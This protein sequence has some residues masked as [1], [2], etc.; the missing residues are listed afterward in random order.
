[1]SA[2]LLVLTFGLT[3]NWIEKESGL[4]L[5]LV[6]GVHFGQ[7]D[8]HKFVWTRENVLETISNLQAFVLGA[9]ALNSRIEIVMTVSPQPMIATYSPDNVL[10][11]N[12]NTKSCLRSAIQTVA[13]ESNGVSYFPS[14]E[15]ATN[16]ASRFCLF[17]QNLRTIS[18]YGVDVIVEAMVGESF[19]NSDQEFICDEESLV[20]D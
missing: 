11:A 7:F 18:K 4:V 5:P 6:P 13:D 19:Q 16:P 8:S 9:K 3:E 14:Y 10:V 15:F 12:C 2:D 17:E 20:D 1:M